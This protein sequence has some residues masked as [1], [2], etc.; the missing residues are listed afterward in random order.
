M[1]DSMPYFLTNEQWYE[2]PDG[3]EIFF[4]DGRGYHIK[5]SAP[6]EAKESYEEFYSC[7]K[8]ELLI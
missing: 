5:D 8:N 2:I 1:M 3:D 7:Q 4:D 6:K